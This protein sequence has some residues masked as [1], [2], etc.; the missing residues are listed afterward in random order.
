ME[1]IVLA[2]MAGFVDADG[3]IGIVSVAATKQYVAQLVVCNCDVK[4]ILLFEQYFG[5]KCRMRKWK[6]DN[7]RPNYEWKITAKK[8]ELAIKQLLPYLQIKDEQARH[9]IKLQE[10]KSRYNAAYLRWNPEIKK[11]HL[12]ELKQIKDLCGAL[13]KRG[14]R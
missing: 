3:S 14:V 10:L 12:S 6:N 2:Y 8:A 5:G 13:N 11:Q 4:P 9:V 1:K 7:W